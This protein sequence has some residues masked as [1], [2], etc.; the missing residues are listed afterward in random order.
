MKLLLQTLVITISLGAVA[1]GPVSLNQAYAAP[2]EAGSKA[3]ASVASTEQH[4]PTLVEEAEELVKQ[5]VD[6]VEHALSSDLENAQADLDAAVSHQGEASLPQLDMNTFP[7]QI[8]WMFVFFTL[9]YV[10]LSTVALPRISRVLE[11]RHNKIAGDLEEANEFRQEAEEIKLAYEKSLVEANEKVRNLM[12]KT[13]AGL[14]QKT[15]AEQ[16]SANEKFLKQIA[17]AEKNIQD[18][19]NKALEGLQEASTV[20]AIEL[21]NKLADIAVNDNEAEAAVKQQFKEAQ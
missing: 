3:P 14:S 21:A 13:Y 4:N 11:R 18:Q 16:Q 2:K 1:L 19:K 20:V 12:T 8:F 5:G 9:L 17:T 10:I 6:A 7:S 15:Y